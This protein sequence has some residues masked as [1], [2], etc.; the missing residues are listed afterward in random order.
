MIPEPEVDLTPE[1]AARW[2]FTRSAAALV[3][4]GISSDLVMLDA[5]EG[6]DLVRISETVYWA[7]DGE[8]DR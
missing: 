7:P 1:Q 6:C 5:R 2:R 3:Q 4:M 8:A